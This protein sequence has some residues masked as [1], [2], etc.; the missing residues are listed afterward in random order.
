MSKLKEVQLRCPSNPSIH[1]LSPTKQPGDDFYEYVN[2]SWLEKN[3][4]PRWRSEYSVSSEIEDLTNIKLLKLLDSYP[5]SIDL[6]PTTSIGHLHTLTQ[7]W[8]HRKIQNE[9]DYLQVCLHELLEVA[10][11]SDICKFLGYLCKSRIETIVGFVSEEEHSKPFYVRAA[12]VTGGLVLPADYYRKSHLKDTEIWRAYERFVSVCSIELGLPFLHKA[13]DGEIELA[14]LYDRTFPDHIKTFK[15]SSL[16]RYIPEF[17]WSEF[18]EGLDV[19]SRWQKRIWILDTP[20]QVKTILHWFCKTDRETSIAVL[21]LHLIKFAAPYIRPAI[22]NAYSDLFHKALLGV[23]IK[24]PEPIRFLNDIKQILPDILCNVYA[25]TQNDH[26]K[27]ASIEAL[28]HSLQKAAS[29]VMQ[30]SKI[31]SRKT[32]SKIQEKIHRMRFEIGKGP[33]TPLPNVTYTQNSLLHSI[34]SV[35]TVRSKQIIDITGKH[36]DRTKSAYACFVVNA[37][38]FPESNHIVMPWGILQWP[39]YCEKA[40]LGWNYGGIGATIAHEITHA[41]DLDGSKFSPRAQYKEWWTRKDRKKFRTETRKLSKFFSKFKHYGHKLDGERT[42][43]ENWADL[44]GLTI[45]LQALKNELKATNSTDS[46]CKEAF[47]L[48]FISY[49]ASW[50]TL[51]RKKKDLYAIL[52]S[53]H[54]PAED[55]VNRMVPQFEEWIDAFD[56]K[57]SDDLYLEPKE[58]LKFF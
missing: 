30:E 13:I 4:I 27:Y 34:V 16:I 29:E 49:A 23:S 37:S 35:Q 58:R 36:S 8:K 26:S 7:I 18:M 40:P 51:I 14:T 55:R 17:F 6:T 53:V 52:T 10:D 32:L 39:N 22:K 2:A 11:L 48:F 54:A 3:K 15:G 12:L 57:E 21:A 42:L 46:E 50:R 19:D 5:K 47:K 9:E 25:T 31:L 44:G 20:E 24:S 45:S 1:P 28:V 38:Y 33:S 41:F 56:I 43:S